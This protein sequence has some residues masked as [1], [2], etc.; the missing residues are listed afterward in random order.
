MKIYSPYLKDFFSSS[1]HI[2]FIDNQKDAD[3]VILKLNLKEFEKAFSESS[4]VIYILPYLRSRGTFKGF[5]DV[6]R[7]FYVDNAMNLPKFKNFVFSNNDI[8]N[9]P[10]LI[11]TPVSFNPH[12]FINQPKLYWQ[13]E[14]KI[15]IQYMQRVYWKGNFTHELRRKVFDYY[16]KTKDPR[17]TIEK[18]NYNIYLKKPELADNINF[19]NDYINEIQNSDMGFNIRGDRPSTHSFFDMIEFGC[20]PININCM[21]LGWENIMDNTEDYMLNFDMRTQTIDYIHNAIVKTLEDQ[22]KIIQMKHNCHNL[23]NTFFKYTTY[24]WADFILAKCIQI[25]RNDFDITKIDNKL[26]C[27]ELLELKDLK[28]KI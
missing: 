24:P 7:G 2:N 23:F 25:Y 6:R 18:F 12:E 9:D 16:A 21:D 14:K 4:K 28:G 20:I 22:D 17:F 5:H 27:Q 11:Q 13:S 26:I 1:I 8:G 10:Y 19:Y 15:N 3:L